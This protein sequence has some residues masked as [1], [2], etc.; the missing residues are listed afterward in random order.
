MVGSLLCA[1]GD[2]PVYLDVGD[3]IILIYD[4]KSVGRLIQLHIHPQSSC[5]LN[6]R[7]AL[8]MSRAGGLGLSG[9]GFALR[10]TPKAQ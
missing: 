5:Q 4:I 3:T 2:Q 9:A 6:V 10:P 7:V 1:G 8:E